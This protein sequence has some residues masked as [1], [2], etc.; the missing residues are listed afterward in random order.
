VAAIVCSLALAWSVGEVAGLQ[1][2]LERQPLRRRWFYAGYAACVAG[3]AGIVLLA[4]DLVW[5]SIAAQ[6][7]NA[8]LLPLVAALLVW[9]AATALPPT[10][11]LRGAYLWLVTGTVALASLAGL[12]GAVAAL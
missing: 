3:G 6:I 10:V 12:A 8:L 11:R 1:H 9:L 4:G 5:L 2:T 7:V